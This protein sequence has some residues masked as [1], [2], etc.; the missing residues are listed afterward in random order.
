[1]RSLVRSSFPEL[2]GTLHSVPD[3]TAQGLVELW[4]QERVEKALEEAYEK[5]G[6]GAWMG[7]ARRQLERERA[8]AQKVAEWQSRSG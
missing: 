6:V 1:M 7:E 4:D 3:I 8:V 5:G 2:H